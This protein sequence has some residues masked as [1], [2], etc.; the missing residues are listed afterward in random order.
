MKKE[1]GFENI[2]NIATF[3]TEGSK[4]SVLTSCRG[5]DI[6]GDTA[7]EIADMIPTER[8]KTWTIKELL[9]GNEKLG[10][11]PNK[12]FIGKLAEYSNLRETILKIEG[13][14]CGRSVHASGVYIFKEGYI[15]QNSMMRAPS[16]Q[17]ITAWDASDSDSVG[18]LKVDV[19]T[20]QAIDKIQK[21]L[22]LLLDDGVI[23]WKGSL[24][25]TYDCYIHPDVLEYDDARMWELINQ[26]RIIDLFQFETA[27]GEQA[28]KKFKPTNLK[29]M[30]KGN[31]AMRLMGG[32]GEDPLDKYVR[33]KENISLWYKEMKEEGLNEDEM[34][35]LEKHLLE[36]FGVSIEQEDL[37]KIS[38][39]SQ[40]SGFDVKWANKARKS[41]A[42]KSEKL[43]DE[44]RIEFYKQGKELGT[45]VE[46][47]D[48][49]WTYVF[50]PQAGLIA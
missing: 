38:M 34:S 7:Q 29:Q 5:L 22:E 36:N 39:D 15:E 49:V 20:V 17:P 6:D 2:L 48:Y 45:R 1:M 23:E 11:K 25:E 33:F 28:I 9:Y 44:T 16:G 42:K 30:A 14:I 21:T 46:L 50:M 8:G 19:L 12:E 40:I 31:S 24:R 35:V 27:V 37:M 47:L 4:S 13:L 43:L 26:G 41:I 3:K 32:S 18:A 10:R